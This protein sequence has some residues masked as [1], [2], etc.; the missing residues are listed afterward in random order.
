MLSLNSGR[1]LGSRERF[2]ADKASAVVSGAICKMVVEVK[3][4]TVEER[5]RQGRVGNWQ[6]GGR[7]N[8]VD[9]EKERLR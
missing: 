4:K 9:G 7:E 5:G 3:K 1:K 6:E 8:G 2:T